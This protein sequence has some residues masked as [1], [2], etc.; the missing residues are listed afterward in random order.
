MGIDYSIFCVRAHQRYRDIAHP[1]YALVRVGVFLSGVST[2]IGFGV[3]C[4]AD[5]SLLRSI[6]ITSFLGI[7]Y[8]LLGTFLLLPPLLDLYFREGR[9][10]NANKKDINQRIRNRYRLLEAYPRLF[11]RFKLRF[12]PMFKDLPLMLASKK[13]IKT[14]VDIGCGYGVPACWCLERFEQTKIFAIDPDPERVRVASLV[15]GDR[16]T[17][18]RGLAPE[19]EFFPVPADVI[20]LLD[21]L[22]YL[23]DET[24]R[25]VFAGS[26]QALGPGGI[27]VARFVIRPEGQPSWFWRLDGCR[28]KLSGHTPWY[29]SAARMAD[30]LAAAG[31]RVT[32]SEVS[33]ANAELV[34]L[35][36]RAGKEVAG[37]N[38]QS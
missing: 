20:L 37:A 1:S 6:G 27:L 3:L 11:A 16:G 9:K 10:N 30:L 8:S 36:G 28:I 29:R 32:V 24:V 4:F 15:I 35:V 23:D 7:A 38:G 31:F 21:M 34:W 12:D 17:I 18:I 19:M 26:F 13:N 33:A 2:L 22:H 14:I 25:A 5:H